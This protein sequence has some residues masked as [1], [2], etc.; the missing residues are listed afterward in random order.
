M[1]VCIYS[2]SEKIW[3]GGQ[4]YVDHLCRFLNDNG[5]ETFIATSEPK[6]FSSPAM[7]MPSVS[8]KLRRLLLSHSLVKDLKERGVRIVVLNDL[9]SLWLAPIFRFH[10]FKVVSLLHLY[11]QERN[12][13]G[14][15]HRWFEYRILKYSSYFAHRIYSVNKD[16]QRVFPVPV[17][18][19]G[20]F[21][22]PWFLDANR[23]ES[24]KYD[25]GLVARLSAEK[26]IPLFVQ[27]IADLNS[28]S[29]RPIRGLI[30]GKGE[31]EPLI[32]NEIERLSMHSLI[33]LK[34]WV[35]RSKLPDVFDQIRCFA[36]TSYHEGFATTLLESHARGVPAICTRSSGFCP[37]FLESFGSVTGIAFDR[38]DLSSRVFLHNIIRF[39]DN[40]DELFSACRIKAQDFTEGKVLGKLCIDFKKMMNGQS[41]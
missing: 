21:I 33:D 20:N 29:D 34:P 24:K 30:V 31:Q 15:G 32:R 36:I 10:G 9:S 40:S 16:N 3:G 28:I 14:F 1:A 26:N 13:A 39:I 18:W 37:E 38:E 22:S 25:L 8:S 2:P 17:E 6:T 27:I 11:L 23:S 7:Q 4:I 5:I 19:I 12:K 35:D 41:G